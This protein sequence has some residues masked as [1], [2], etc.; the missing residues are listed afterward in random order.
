MTLKPDCPRIQVQDT[1]GTSFAIQF[2]HLDVGGDE[3]IDVFKLI[4]MFLGFGPKTI[5]ELFNEEEE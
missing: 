2:D 4:L 3:W 5:E 1:N